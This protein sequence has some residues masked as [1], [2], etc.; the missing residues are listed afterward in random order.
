MKQ[1]ITK[2]KKEKGNELYLEWLERNSLNVDLSNKK[3][4]LNVFSNDTALEYSNEASR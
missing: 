3:L 1:D 4:A 2:M